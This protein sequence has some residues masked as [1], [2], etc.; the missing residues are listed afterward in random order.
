M[1]DVLH[2]P[3]MRQSHVKWFTLIVGYETKP[4]DYA[5]TIGQRQA[6]AVKD[7]VITVLGTSGDKDPLQFEAS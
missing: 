4:P 6:L 5:M 3:P 1:F 7:C 2:Y